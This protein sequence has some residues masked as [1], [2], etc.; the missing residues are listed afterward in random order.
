MGEKKT[1]L[2]VSVDL[3]RCSDI[4]AL[5]EAVGDEMCLLKTHVDIIEDFSEDFIRRLQDIAKA[6][7][8]MIFEDRKFA[9]IGNTVKHQYKGS[10]IT[11]D[12]SYIFRWSIQDFIMGSLH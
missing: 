9:D 2:C 1:N 11:W 10:R 3:T 6:K 7:R 5:A 12:Y 4:L 8:F